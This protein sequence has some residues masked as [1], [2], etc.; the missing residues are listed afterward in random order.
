[1]ESNE[2][3]IILKQIIPFFVNRRDIY[4]IQQKDGTYRIEKK[5]LTDKVL[6]HHITGKETIGAYQLAPKS[7]TV[8]YICIDIDEGTI[9]NPQE[10]AKKIYYRFQQGFINEAVWLEA[11]RFPDHSYHIYLLLNSVPGDVAKYIGN[12]G[13]KKIG[14]TGIEV[15]P[16]QSELSKE[17]PYG[18]L[19][20]IPLGLHQEKGKWSKFLNPETFQP[21]L[22]KELLTMRQAKVTSQQIEKIRLSITKEKSEKQKNYS[23]QY[24]VQKGSSDLDLFT[25]PCVK[26]FRDNSIPEGERHNTFDKNFSIMYRNSKG[27]FEGVQNFAE[28]LSHNQ[29]SF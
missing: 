29:Q 5:L 10:T 3:A 16:K 17:K 1:M 8:K 19:V 23:N 7:N 9:K 20:K 4:A 18:N 11:S 2:K 6:L 21:L 25:V 24:T 13:L 27:T 12:Q 28:E 22:T 15:F 26:T 14:I